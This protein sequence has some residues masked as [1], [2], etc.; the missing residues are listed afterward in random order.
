MAERAPALQAQDKLAF[1]LSLVPYLMDRGSV[2]VA[3]AATHFGVPVTQIRRAVELI[4]VSGIPG[5]TT[6]YQHGDLFD[7][8]WDDFEQNDVIV[9]T[10][11]V[12]IDDS[13]RFSA[14]EAAALIA[15]LQYLSSL[16]ENAD[17]QAI[18]TLMSKLARG[19]SGAPS[20]VAVEN[21]ETNQLLAL[22][23]RAVDEG[24][25][26]EFDYSGVRGQIERRRVDPLRV[27][28]LDADWYLRGYD[29]LREAVRTFRL[30]RV[31][32][33]AVSDQPISFRAADVSLPDT[34]FEGSPDDIV[35][36]IEIDAAAST[37]LDDYAPETIEDGPEG[38]TRLA[39]R[40][41]HFGSLARLVAGLPGGP[42]VV[43]PAAARAAVADW[44]TR[45]THRYD[46]P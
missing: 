24:V 30:D 17:R 21:S 26:L 5:E 29:H 1:L 7:I 8:A 22:V 31:S 35:V 9:L 34:L 25:Q 36:E 18:A 12:A 41:N 14:R 6:Q 33:A 32:D 27:E 13:P 3:E 45:A 4:A 39:L 40:V 43:A 28:S 46:Q 42:V 44:A 10:N 20:Q 11:L 37:L 2:S 19:A 16:P 23:R 15:G 38:R